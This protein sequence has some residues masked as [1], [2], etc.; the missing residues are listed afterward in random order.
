MVKELS[1]SPGITLNIASSGYNGGVWAG[2][3]N[4]DIQGLGQLPSIC[5]DVRDY[6]PSTD[7]PYGVVA[8]KD[9]PDPLAGPMHAAKAADLSKLLDAYWTSGLTNDQA[10]G[11]QLAAWEIVD[12]QIGSYNIATG[13]FQAAGN[14]LASGWATTYLTGFVSYN[15]PAGSYLALTNHDVVET[16]SGLGYYQD[17]VVRDPVPVP[18]AILLGGIGVSLVG[19]LRRRRAL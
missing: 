13:N 4:L 14:G 2:V 6:S 19:W 17:Y 15:G 18:G 9:A 11:L 12:E 5:I 16:G 8:L 1:V 7:Q 10:A 3:Y